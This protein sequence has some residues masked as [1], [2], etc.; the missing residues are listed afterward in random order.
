MAP[1]KKKA[2]PKKWRLLPHWHQKLTHAY[3]S[4]CIYAAIASQVI[5]N[6]VSSLAEVFG[7]WLT[8]FLLVAALL[9]GV[10]KQESVSGK[11]A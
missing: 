8:G 10:V 5:L 1:R 4:W 9:V 6:N 11:D 7:L 2:P 3:S